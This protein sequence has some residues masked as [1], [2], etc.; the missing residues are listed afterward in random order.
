VVA[1]LMT[2]DD[3]DDLPALLTAIETF[4]RTDFPTRAGAFADAIARHRPHVV[5]LQEV[6]DVHIDLTALG[7]PIAL[8]QE[9]LPLLQAELAAR[10]L[11]YAV[12]ATVQNFAATP[13]PGVSLVDFDAIL[14]D[15]SR[16][17]VDFTHT[18]LFSHNL[19]VVAPG[20][21][22]KRGLV[23]LAATIAGTRYYFVSTHLEPDIAGAD[24][25]DL[26]AAQAWEMAVA[27]LGDSTPAFIMGDLN[28]LPG[29]PMYRV[30]QEA[31]LVDLWAE[32]RPGVDGYT[33]P[34]SPDLANPR[35]EL[36]KRIDY[37]W[38]RGMGHPVA[39]LTGRI[40]L[41]GVHP[42]ERVQGPFYKMWPSDHA[43]LVADLITG[44]GRP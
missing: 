36:S 18:Q 22:L 9:F 20:V 23:E 33:N 2:S 15:V 31:G 34:R 8:D 38:A 25:S 41:L 4:Q 44:T 5:G 27:V 32:L 39:G 26:R 16:A 12:A 21:E 3:A 29:S 11:P 35:N 13:V 42:A 37:I 40:K 7:L 19:G 10:G 6:S 14:V 1:A 30:L 24:L 28:D 43:G 17:A